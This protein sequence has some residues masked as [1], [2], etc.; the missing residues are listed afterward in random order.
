MNDAPAAS[1]FA[2]TPRFT[3]RRWVALGLV[4]VYAL[5]VLWA[6]LH[7]TTVTR[8]ASDYSF[9]QTDAGL[10]RAIVYRLDEGQGYY[11]AVAIEQPARN[12]PT[13]PVMT[14]RE[15]TLAW[16]TSVLGR[17]VMVTLMCMLSAAAILMSIWVFERTERRR[18]GWLAGVLLSTVALGIFALPGG[19]CTHEVWMALLVYLGLMCRG[20]G[21][22][23]TSMVLLLLAS[24]V[25]ELA[26]PVMGLMLLQAWRRGRRREAAIWAVAVLIFSAF[27]GWHAHLV[28]ELVDA[29]G[30]VSQG[31][32]A[33]GGWPF[34]VDS[35][36]ETSVLSALPY[37]VAAVAVPLGMLGWFSRSGPLFE[38]VSIV[39]AS[40]AALFCVV[41]RPD[42]AYWGA[43]L[44]IFV[45]VGLGMGVGALRGVLGPR[46]DVTSSSPAGA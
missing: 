3:D 6:V 44:G 12:Y 7:G 38:T 14:V 46:R 36:R 23:R 16:A 39:L 28:A 21:W 31:W 32:L 45:I 34:V 37:W 22:T 24:V 29:S 25:R 1:P 26:A 27:Y 11:Q 41:G 8:Q 4:V 33:V 10:Y 20:V 19:V 15:P 43:F 5:L 2:W 13:S 9:E 42:N 17:T 40:Y 30:P 35:V 18:R